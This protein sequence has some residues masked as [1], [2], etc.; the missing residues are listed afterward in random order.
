MEEVKTD[1]TV[2]EQPQ[3]STAVD[4]WNILNPAAIPYNNPNLKFSAASDSTG[5]LGFDTPE[6]QAYFKDAD[7]G[8]KNAM[9]KAN[10]QSDAIKIAQ[11]RNIFVASQKAIEQDGIMTQLAMGVLPAI[12]SP[13]TLLPFG[14]V[15]K[16]AQMAKAVSTLTK[17]L[18]L[19]AAGALVGATANIADEALFDLQGMPTNYLGA[20]AIGAVFGGS[21]GFLGGMLSGP[22]KKVVANAISPENDTL[23]KDFLND[24][25]ILITLDENG[26]PKLQD[27][28][29]MDKSIIDRIPWLGDKLR[30]DV[31]TVYQGESSLMRGFMGRMMSATVSQKD[32]AGN[33]LPINKTSVDIK[34]E[35]KG[36]HNILTQESQNAYAEAKQIGYKGSNT[37]FNKDVWAVYVDAMNKQKNDAATFSNQKTAGMPTDTITDAERN[38]LLKTSREAQ[39][40]YYSKN[41]VQFTGDAHLVKGAEAYRKYFQT[42]LKRSQEMGIKELQGLNINKLYAP[43]TYNYKGIHKG[44]IS[45]EVVRSEVRNGLANDV[46]NRGMSKEKLEAN[47]DEIVS[48]LNSSAFD[49]NNLTTSYMIK[50]LPF[51]THLKSKK[52]YLN[53]K[54]MPNILHSNFE[55]ITGAYHYKMSGRQGVQYAFGTDNLTEIMKLVEDEHLSQGILYNPKEVQ[56]FERV[57]KD[58]L[59]DLRMNQLADTPAWTFTRSL[60]A[61]NSSRLG[62][63][64]GGN[65][66]IELASAVAMNGVKA[67]VSGRLLKSLKN[68][69][70]LLYTHKGKHDE[71]SQYLINSGYM[72]DTL[73]TSR[74]NRYADTEQGFNSGTLENGLS[75]MNDKLMKY[76]GMRYF[77][78]VMEDYTGGAIITQ[79][80]GG[81]VEAKRLARWGLSVSDADSL[82][83][84]LHEVTKEGGWDI[85]SLSQVERDRLQLAVSRGIDEIVVQGDSIHLPAWMKAPGPFTKV[86]TQFMRFPMIAQETLLRKGMAEE[87]AQMIGGVMSSIATFM[88]IKYLREQ[89]AIATGSIHPIDAKYDYNNFS[90]EDYLRVIGEALNYTAPLGFMTSVWNYGAI[91]TGQPELGR[92]WQS[93]NGMSSLLGPSGGL[94]EDVIQIIRAGV[95]GKITDDRTL[96]RFKSMTP[97]MNLPLVNEGSK[98]LI[99]EFGD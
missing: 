51:A 61:Y 4:Y 17:G 24:P 55:D 87:Q 10:N 70:D 67:L 35:T 11:R 93:K 98:Y 53:E 89:A 71:F 19:G 36:I 90:D 14:V 16:G 79:L 64:F 8:T 5:E 82:G 65:Q 97:F 76:N 85:G 7:G 41:P 33:I 9:M 68:S 40:E 1:T 12:A 96:Q 94:G 15:F 6:F 32:S 31:H 95:E 34:R 73:H 45:Q 50:E 48:M 37:Q 18:Q 30:S 22:T 3:E 77:M 69:S 59:G 52:L 38:A 86:L 75:W 72:E 28:G 44:D 78:G 26:I 81:N 62:G 43:R 58:V 21:L 66:F 2:V 29:Q 74:I 57:V 39:D 80:K 88:G 99:E 56:A 46:R 54:F 84:R 60:T 23:T 83:K 25:S 27:V 13:S 42:M 92:E 63:G 47:T 49:L 20:G 91:A